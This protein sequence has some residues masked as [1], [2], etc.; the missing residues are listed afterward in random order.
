MTEPNFQEEMK[1]VKF[2]DTNMSLYDKFVS[3]VN[4]IMIKIFGFDYDQNG[5]TAKGIEVALTLIDKQ[6]EMK[7]KSKIEAMEAN[8]RL[9]ED[10]LSTPFGD[11]VLP[12]DEELN[13]LEEP[14]NNPNF[15]D[16]FKCK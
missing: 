12:T 11:V 14:D 2:K 8:D 7:E 13:N 5:I 10:L 16:P 9:A 3:I 4:D 15:E 1:N 6:A